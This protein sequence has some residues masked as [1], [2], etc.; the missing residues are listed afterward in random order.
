MLQEK[1]KQIEE[2]TRMLRQKQRLVETLRS[3]LELGKMAGGVASEREGSNKRTASPNVKTQTL[4]QASAVRPT[5]LPNGLVKVKQEAE[6][7]KS[8]TGVREEAQ[9]KRAVQPMQ[10]SKKSPD[11][12]PQTLVKASAIQPPVPPN[13]LLKVK[14]ETETEASM[15]GVCDAVAQSK[16]AWSSLCRA[17]RRHGSDWFQ[18]AE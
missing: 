13:G 5:V 7:E 4:V 10:Y 16:S 12:Q 15:T 6:T 14:Q 11:V 8:R 1:D 18:Q 17:P 3:Q 2:L 9:S